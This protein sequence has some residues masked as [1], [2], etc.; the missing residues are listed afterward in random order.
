MMRSQMKLL[1]KKCFV[2]LWNR[3]YSSSICR[4]FINFWENRWKKNK[5]ITIARKISCFLNMGR[6][7]AKLSNDN[8]TGKC[9]KRYVKTFYKEPVWRIR[10]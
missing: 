5:P 6:N 2:I 10:F 4:F 7:L 9:E 1:I 3:I 8:A